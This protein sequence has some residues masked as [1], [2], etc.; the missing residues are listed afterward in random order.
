MIYSVTEPLLSARLKLGGGR[1]GPVPALRELGV[2]GSA[3][4]GSEL[5][6]WA[7]LADALGARSNMPGMKG[8]STSR[9]RPFNLPSPAQLF[10]NSGLVERVVS[11]HA[12]PADGQ[13]NQGS[14]PA[15]AGSF[16]HK[17]SLAVCLSGCSRSLCPSSQ[18]LCTGILE[19][20]LDSRPQE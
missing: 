18:D 1:A 14:L 5:R 3:Q 6:G 9:W 17:P 7:A 12:N 2:K 11:P 16:R 10:K 8:S 4:A 19:G 13:P 20:K 15:F